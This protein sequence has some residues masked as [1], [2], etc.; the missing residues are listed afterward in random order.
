MNGQATAYDDF[1]PKFN[2]STY[3]QLTFLRD[4]TFS[5]LLHWSYKN[6]NATLNQELMDEG[7]SVGVC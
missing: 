7:D 1:Q 2:L 5:F 6:Y 3:N 4:F